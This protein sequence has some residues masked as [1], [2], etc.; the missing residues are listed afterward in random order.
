M[1]RVVSILKRTQKIFSDHDMNVYAGYSTL[2]ILMAL[3]PLLIL[4]VSLVSLLPQFSTEDLVNSLLS[5]FPLVSEI[6][7]MLTGI[8]LSLS[9]TSVSV[10]ASV[11]ALSTL[12]AASNGISA[13]QKSLQ[14]IE[15][16]SQN[17]IRNKL[18]AL[19]Y[20][21]LFILMIPALLI[22][23]VFSRTIRSALGNF[24]YTIHLHDIAGRIYSFLRLSSVVVILSAIVIVLLMYTF[25]PGKTRKIKDQLPGAVFTALL[26]LGFS[27]AFAYF[28]PRF[29]KASAFYGSLAAVFLS[30]MWLKIIMTI[31]FYGAALNN[32]LKE[33]AAIDSETL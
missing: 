11:S 21:V 23:Q 22:S 31:L 33:E 24:L 18:T 19:A 27:A 5:D 16:F 2:C 17:G 26:W 9:N 7:E 10:V 6:R 4:I 29:W 15:G 14:E 25:L 1:K 3:I 30:A 28:I 8:I 32:A 13:V 20:T 12:W